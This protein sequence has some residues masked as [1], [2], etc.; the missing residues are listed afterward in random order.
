M[1]ISMPPPTSAAFHTTRWSR[2]VLARE[3]SAQGQEAL[4]QLCAAYYS[5]VISFLRR[6]GRQEDAARDLAHDFFA[7]VLAGRAINHAEQSRGRF[8]SYLLGAVKHFLSHQR[9]AAL[10]LRRGGG[11]TPIS[12]DDEET[13]ALADPAQISPDEAFDR[14]WAHTVLARAMEA[15]R[16]EQAAE[17][18]GDA[19]ARLQ[20]WLSGEAAHGDQA[21]LAESLGMNVNTL[22][23]ATHRLRQRFRAL[24]KAEIA[25]TLD[26]DSAVDEEMQ[27]LFSA[28]RSR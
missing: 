27:V 8:R 1:L 21:A 6:E 3:P 7:I 12:V 16:Q 2:V 11:E 18:K 26:D 23:A 20:P 15:L 9:E 5:P 17:G 13:P 28:L 4:Q 22:K 24:V 25:V 14:E 10:R 19:F